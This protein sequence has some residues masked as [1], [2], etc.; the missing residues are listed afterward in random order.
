[1][2]KNIVLAGILGGAALFVWESVAHMATGLGEAGVR[3]LPHEAAIQAAIKENVAD[4]GFY[5]FPAPE[6]KPGMTGDQRSKAM[7]ASFQRARTEPSGI[8]VVYPQGRIYELGTLLSVQFAGDVLAILI[9]AFLLSKAV[10]LKGYLPRALFVGLM[11][12]LPA[13]QVD[14]PQ[15]NWY[16]FPTVFTAAQFVV[17]LVGFMLAGLVVAKIV[18]AV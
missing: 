5:L 10:S 17:H 9:A 4:P 6:D 12:L 13:L 14:I 8:M 3:A 11:G 15:W 1:M 16:G 2:L 7:E 18:R